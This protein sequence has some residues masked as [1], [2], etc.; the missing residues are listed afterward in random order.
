MERDNV[1][2]R[3]IAVKYGVSDTAIKN[4]RK[5]VCAPSYEIRESSS[6]N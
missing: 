2:T 1:S 5:G 6:N 3:K 4:W